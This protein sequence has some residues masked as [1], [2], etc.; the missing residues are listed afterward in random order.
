MENLRRVFK[1]IKIK[2]KDTERQDIVSE[3]S[4]NIPS[5]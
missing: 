1:R 4:E 5:T 2:Y 3:I